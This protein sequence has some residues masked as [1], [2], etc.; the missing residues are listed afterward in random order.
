VL[1]AQVPLVDGC[2]VRLPLLLSTDVTAELIV[3]LFSNDGVSM[4]TSEPLTAAPE[5]TTTESITTQR[6]IA[7]TH[8][9]EQ[10]YAAIMAERFIVPPVGKYATVRLRRQ[11]TGRCLHFQRLICRLSRL[12]QS[13]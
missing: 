10:H 4:A 3:P 6:D 11:S 7:S 12:G 1:V 5:F 9:A 13:Q 8:V 2:S